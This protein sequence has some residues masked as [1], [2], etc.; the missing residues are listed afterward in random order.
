VGFNLGRTDGSYGSA[1]LLKVGARDTVE[2]AGA[3]CQLLR[4]YTLRGRTYSTVLHLWLPAA[5]PTATASI[6]G[7]FYAREQGLL[8]YTTNRR[9]IWYRE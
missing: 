6:T 8:A 5:L 9:Q 4:N 7:V 1:A 2:T 3:R